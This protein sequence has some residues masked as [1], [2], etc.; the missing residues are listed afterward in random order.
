MPI[1]T[2]MSS[3]LDWLRAGY[4]DG[5]PETDY[6]PLM[7]VLARRLSTDE[8]KAVAA[9]LSRSGDLPIDNVE[10]GVLIS[11]ITNDMPSADDVNRVRAKLA[12]GGWP[13]ADTRTLDQLD[14]G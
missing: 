1:T 10:I 13:L 6:I 11:K 9:D 4:P 2:L 3:I 8:V 5:I 12:L 7:L 14:E